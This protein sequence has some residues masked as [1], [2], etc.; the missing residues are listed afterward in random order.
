MSD[1]KKIAELYDKKTKKE[2][3]NTLLAQSDG[4]L[5]NHNGI[6][7]PGEKI[8]TYS[9]RVNDEKSRLEVLHQMEKNLVALGEKYI[10]AQNGAIGLDAGCGA[11]GAGILIAKK[12]F[13]IEG[14]TL[15]KEQANYANNCSAKHRV[16]EYAKF[17]VGDMLKLPC[18]D[19]HYSFIWACESTEHISN[20]AALFKEFRRVAKNGARLILITWS[21]KDLSVKKKVDE[22]YLTDIHS[23]QE[24]LDMALKQDWLILEQVNLK[25]LTSPYWGVRSQSMNKTGSEQFMAPGF[26]SGALEYWLFVFE[27]S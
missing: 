27:K 25:E 11:G 1:N 23:K 4:L 13:V 26:A 14:V 24:Y 8:E 2:N 21:A 16:A 12:G 5:F 22:H 18:K 17:F 3:L 7:L 6:I 19:A 9:A 20:L 10:M 15:S